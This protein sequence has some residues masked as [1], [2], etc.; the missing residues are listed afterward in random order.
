MTTTIS[1]WYALE[2]YLQADRIAVGVRARDRISIQL[3]SADD[4]REIHMTREQ[5]IRLVRKLIEAV[6]AA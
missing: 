1:I 5:T 2:T 4:G 3:G 6:E